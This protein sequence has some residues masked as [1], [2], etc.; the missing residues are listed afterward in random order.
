MER[1]NNNTAYYKNGMLYDV[2]PRDNSVSL[3]ENRDIAY[4]ARYIVLNGKKYDLYNSDSISSI[5]LPT[6]KPEETSFGYVTRNLAY[7]M[8]MRAK[9][10]F[11]PE[12]AIPLVFQTV[13]LMIRSDISWAKKD[14]MRHV[15]QLDGI[16]KPQYA[17]YLVEQLIKIVP[18]VADDSYFKKL[19]IKRQLENARLCHTDL[20]EMTSLFTTCSE[21]AK[22]QGR[23]YSISGNDKRFP[24]LPEQVFEYGGIHLGCTHSFNA[25]CYDIRKK[26]MIYTTS[27]DGK[28]DIVYVDALKCSN[29][30]FVDNRTE[31]EKERYEKLTKEREKKHR[32]NYDS[33]VKHLKRASEYDWICANLPDLAPKSL[34]GY[35]RMKHT[36][37]KNYLKIKE[38]AMKLNKELIEDI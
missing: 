2:S 14:Y 35:T 28:T 8:N 21:C 26:I 9:R 29:R 4:N 15:A 1:N 24:K 33:L 10:T 16:N 22:Y 27:Q 20:I 23:V 18:S 6:F 5:E 37:S 30:P 13:N 38:A 32:W 12:L 19:Y 31:Q 17:K 3:D 36:S 7:I 11:A 25:F 34:G